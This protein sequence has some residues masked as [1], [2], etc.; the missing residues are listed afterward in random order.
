M[1]RWSTT[2]LAGL[3]LLTT[4]MLLPACAALAQRK[5]PVIANL[6]AP[7]ADGQ[8][9]SEMGDEKL[10]EIAGLNSADRSNGTGFPLLGN[11]LIDQKDI[12]TSPGHLHWADGSWLFPVAAATGG[13][14]STDRSF[15]QALSIS[16]NSQDRLDRKST[17]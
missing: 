9:S 14:L 17:R 11:L 13:L 1:N 12:W 16:R 10:L 4:E 7:Y 2:I 3:C 15:D 5:Q 6:S 8:P